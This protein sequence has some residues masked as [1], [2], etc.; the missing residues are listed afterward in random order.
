LKKKKIAV[1]KKN[2]TSILKKK[3]IAIIASLINRLILFLTLRTLGF[4]LL[5]GAGPLVVVSTGL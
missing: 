2:L 3:K 4:G 1:L 5:G